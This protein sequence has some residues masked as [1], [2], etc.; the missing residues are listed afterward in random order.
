MTELKY[1]FIKL[2]PIVRMNL[3]RA[4]RL[5]GEDVLIRACGILGILCGIASIIIRLCK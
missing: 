3:E 5:S 1:H 4:K 2:E